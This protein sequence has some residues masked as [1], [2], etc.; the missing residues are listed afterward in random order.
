[1]HRIAGFL[2][3]A[4]LAPNAHAADV[5]VSRARPLYE[6]AGTALASGLQPVPTR[7]GRRAFHGSR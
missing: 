1:M 7:T 5:D 2:A 4:V 6:D 3:L